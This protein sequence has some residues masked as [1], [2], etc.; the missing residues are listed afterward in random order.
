MAKVLSIEIGSSMIKIVEM[1]FQAKKPKIYKCVDVKTPDGAVRDGYLDPE[2][3]EALRSTISGTL[4]ENK[5]RAK[6]VLFTVF[7]G[8]IISRE[9]TVPILKEHQIGAFIES[10]ANEY[11]PIELNDYKLA[12]SVIESYYEGDNAGRHKV[13]V[14]AAENSLFVPY[15]RLAAALGLH[16]MDIDYAANSAIQAAR[17]SAGANAIMVVKAEPEYALITILQQGTMRMQRTLNYSI[18][19]GTSGMASEAEN[20]EMLVGT[21]ARMIDFYA[22]NNEENKVEQIYLMGEGS[23]EQTLLDMMA[24]QTGLPSRLLDNVRSAAATKSMAD[25]HVNVFAAAIGAGIK[26]VGF[27]AEKEK[28]RHETNYVSACFLM[29]LLFVVAAGGLSFISI[30]P[31]NTALAEQQSLQ[32]KQQQLEPARVVHDQYLGLKDF[33]E[34]LRYGNKLTEHFN[35]GIVAFLEE[36]ESSLPAEVELTDFSSDDAQCVMTI[37]VGDKETA[38]GIIQM[39]RGFESLETV[40]VESLIEEVT[41]NTLEGVM[42]EVLEGNEVKTINFTVTCTYKTEVLEAPVPSAAPPAAAGT[43]AA[44][45]TDAAAATE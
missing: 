33:V 6:R 27:D 13:L 3:M 28:E 34:Q 1:D 18:G 31:Y 25:A 19:R 32:L 39:L 17:Q 40:T 44:A 35:D 9:I 38:A 10:N 4:K 45:T 41:E 20:N 36:L 15:E 8:K 30:V 29:I 24:E 16:I 5:M 43:D 22:S 12:H 23:R 21:V 11:F 14:M 37:R 7:S 42:E 26:S 2:K